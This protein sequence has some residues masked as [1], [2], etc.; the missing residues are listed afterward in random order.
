MRVGQ[1]RRRDSN[2]A[3]I[4]SALRKIGCVQVFRETGP[5]GWGLISAVLPQMQAHT[6]ADVALVEDLLRAMPDRPDAVLSDAAAKFATSGSG[7]ANS[8]L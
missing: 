2:E 4:A 1:N 5:A 7:L 8:G 3:A 6:D